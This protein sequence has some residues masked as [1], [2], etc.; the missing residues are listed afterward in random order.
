MKGNFLL[1]GVFFVKRGENMAEIDSLEIRISASMEKASASIDLLTKKLGVLAQGIQAIGSN[2]GIDEF[3]QKS[4]SLSTEMEHMGKRVSDSMKPIQEQAKKATKDISQIAAEFQNKFKDIPVKVDFSKPESELKK[5]QN[6]AENAQN[7]LTRIMTSSTADKQT[8]S[9]EKWSIA[10]AQANNAIEQLQNKISENNASLNVD[11]N[12]EEIKNADNLI[13]QMKLHVEQM[14]NS[15]KIENPVNVAELTDEQ[16]ALFKELE[17]RAISAAQTIGQQF[18][19]I[20]ENINHPLNIQINGTEETSSQ[21]GKFASDITNQLSDYKDRLTN[22][23]NMTKELEKAG[24][25]KTDAYAGAIASVEK[26]RA[27]VEEL[28]AAINAQ[29]S[30][31]AGNADSDIESSLSGTMQQ[32]INMRDVITQ[33]FSDLKSGEIFRALSDGMKDFAKQAQIVAGIK[34]HTEEY[35]NL[36][37]DIERV[38]TELEKL[39]QKQR[40]LEAS[41]TSKESKDWENVASQIETAQRRLEQYTAQR[42]RMEGTGADTE[43]SG[44]LANQS[45]IKSGLAVAGE[46]MASLRQKIGEIGGAVSQAAGNIPV[47]GRVAKETAFLAQSAFNGL[48]FAMSGIMSV[49]SSVFNVFSKIGAAA[50]S[51]ASK[52]KKAVSAFMGLNKS[53]K[54][55][56]VSLAGGFKTLLKYAFGIRSAYALI[57]KLRTAIVDGFKNLAVYSDEVNSSLSMLKSSLNTFKNASA[58]ALSPLLN[59]MAPALNTIIQL[60]IKATNAINQLLSAL[61][62][63]GMWIKAKDQMLDFASGV[64]SAAKAAQKSVR[65][66]DELKVINTN[67]G[68]GDGGETNP[69]DMFETLPIDEKF[70][71]WAGK[72]KAMWK[73]ADF[74][75]LGSVIGDW[76]KN[77]LDNIDWDG[78]QTK[79]AKL[80]SSLATFL[81]GIF[82][83]DGLGYSI[84]NTLAQSIN[85]A[86]EFLNEFVHKLHWDSLGKFIAE[87]LNGLFENIDWDLIKDTL[88]SGAKGLAD[89]INSFDEFLNWSAISTT[90]SNAFNTLVGTI[91]IFVGNVDWKQLG[92]DIGKTISDAWTGIDW[93]EVG[94]MVGESFIAFFDFIS[95][96]IENVD[97]EGVAQTFEDFITG[98]DWSGVADSFFEAVG[99]AFGGLSMVLG[100][101]LY[102]A[103]D[104]AKKYFQG[105]IEECGGNV[106]EG[107]LKGIV[108][109]IT[110]IG[111]WVYDHVFSPFIKG[112][113]EAFGIHSPSTVM[114][115]QGNYIIEGL[116]NGIT[117]LVDKVTETWESM[118]STAVETWNTVKESLSETW[119]NIKSDAS[120]KFDTIKSNV[121]E[122]WENLKS[123][124]SDKWSTIKS[125]LSDVWNDTKE[126]ASETFGNI[127][128]SITDSWENLKK[129]TGDIWEQIKNVI[130]NPIN[131]IIGFINGLIGGVVSGI[132]AM[133]SAL[134]SISFDIPDWIPGIGGGKFGFDIPQ[135]SVP[136]IP[137]LAKGGI[138]MQYTPA[139]IGEAGA[140]AI[141]PLTN[142]RAMG[143][144]ADSILD[145]ISGGGY[146]GSD[147]REREIYSVVYNAV[148]AALTNN[149][150]LKE[151][152]EMVRGILQK[153][154]IDN[155]IITRS[156]I[157]GINETT[158]RTGK[159]PLLIWC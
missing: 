13:E 20:A 92:A 49:G 89:A 53:S 56:N 36:L 84:G 126:N 68:S 72:L 41:G 90:I 146:G 155:G 153:P 35:Q 82:E 142:S 8:K 117:S 137:M 116:L 148:S 97:W 77:M 100:K 67:D 9:I 71:D 124:T 74:T 19:S 138:A 154:V 108:D 147:D 132:N 133:T 16:F 22:A 38:E 81:N 115:E 83:T 93:A 66:F 103:V 107:I 145:N 159:S 158:R 62:G 135:I 32:L 121:S 42:Y 106:V 3:I 1:C 39:E 34:V 127:K 44:G 156:A 87:T 69:A 141:L 86:F 149:Q 112:F 31:S 128:D 101:L 11:I 55:L 80:G 88:F 47:I 75:E 150:L 130:K 21:L 105:K 134:N 63:K 25:T 91:R 129:N 23:I 99:A 152:K 114:E 109:A 50:K 110:G 78:I 151:Q 157:N 64:K 29:Q 26:Y 76:L 65:A 123:D 58:A 46:A 120:T 30:Q 14:F 139:I 61:F 98:I 5:F 51:L 28:T 104:S 18:D 113:K 102:D 37:N 33:T 45:W 140:E 10:L 24:A 119:E 15:G 73:N 131:A 136:K 43:F 79:A 7:A 122:A 6:Q 111:Q 143:M 70:M 17:A 59:A 2:K 12:T 60:C 94:A 4:Q 54:G 96:A 52:L 27:K 48:K 95:S 144:I 40:D 85:T 118:K 57:N 125:D